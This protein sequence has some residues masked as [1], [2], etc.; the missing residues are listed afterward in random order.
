MAETQKPNEQQPMS[1]GWTWFW[2][3]A[4]SHVIVPLLMGWKH[5]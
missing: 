1:A 5:L 2:L 3:V 4:I